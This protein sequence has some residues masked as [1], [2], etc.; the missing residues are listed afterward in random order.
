[1]LNTAYQN[2]KLNVESQIDSMVFNHESQIA[3]YENEIVNFPESEEFYRAEI[4]R[5]QAELIELVGVRDEFMTMIDLNQDGTATLFEDGVFPTNRWA[6]Q[7]CYFNDNSWNLDRL[8]E[9][10]AFFV[11]CDAIDVQ[12]SAVGAVWQASGQM[13]IQPFTLRASQLDIEYE[14]DGDIVVE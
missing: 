2:D 1:M 9:D 7:S 13:C 6:N 12:P 14:V 5:Y 8:P 10:P 3:Y 4:E 11:V